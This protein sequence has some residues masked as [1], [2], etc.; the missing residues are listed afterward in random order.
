MEPFERIDAELSRIAAL[1]N[2][3]YFLALRIRGT[4]P[5][6]AFKTYPQA[7]LD[8]YM[9]NGYL[10]RDPI[11]TWSMTIG[12][13]IR[14]SSA[15]LPDPFRV[16]SQA[17]EYGLNYGASIAH[18]PLRSLTVCSIARSDREFSD[19]EI[20]TVRQIVIGLHDLTA[21]PGS[22]TTE[23]RAVLSAMAKGTSPEA[24]AAALGISEAAA[25]L[26]FRQVCTTLFASTS[27]EAVQR[28][29]DYKLL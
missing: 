22:L 5:L 23:Q 14:W 16:L 15:F 7:W 9:Q 29:Q 17:A 18:G 10:L 28:A 2:A 24:A 19:D 26:R 20:E 25:R 12:G 27:N 13:T 11:T 8:R 6:M 3:G 4:S 1:A 21:L